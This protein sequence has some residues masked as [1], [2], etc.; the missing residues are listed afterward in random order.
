MIEMLRKMDGSRILMKGATL[1][2]IMDGAGKQY[3]SAYGL[4]FM[5]VIAVMFDICVD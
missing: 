4:Y 5:S 3:R 2:E 1:G